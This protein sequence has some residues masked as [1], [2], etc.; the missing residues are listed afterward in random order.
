[1][2]QKFLLIAICLIVCSCFTTIEGQDTEPKGQLWFCWEATVNPSLNSQFIELQDEF[3]GLFQDND[4]SYTIVAWTDNNFHYYFFYPVESYDDKNMIYDALG[5]IVQQFGEEKWN[6]MWEAVA[7]HR[8]YFLRSHPEMSYRAEERRITNE[9]ATF[10]VWD[11]FYLIPSKQDEIYA[12]GKEFSA[13]L[14]SKN[15]DDNILMLADD[16]GFEG[17]TLIGVL[18]GK[19]PAD[20][21]SQNRK[22]WE[23]LGEEGQ[24]MVQKWMSYVRKREYKQFWYFEKLSYYPNID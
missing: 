20:F 12:L 11:M 24:K 10:A 19:D 15:Y 3:Q 1:M 16:L 2:R 22:M 4:F 8:T 9:E 7:S 18:Y 17:S 6:K 13:L 5:S 23:L 14:K 21:W